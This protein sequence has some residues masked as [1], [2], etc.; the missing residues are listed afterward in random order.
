MPLKRKTPLKSS[1]FKKK[2]KTLLKIVKGYDPAIIDKLKEKGLV[3]SASSLSS[4]RKPS[5]QRGLFERIWNERPHLCEVCGK[6]IAEATASNFSHILPKGMY[7]E[8][9]LDPRNVELWC[10][11]CHAVWH[12]KPHIVNA[13]PIAWSPWI[14]VTQKRDEL[15]K[16]AHSFRV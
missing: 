14:R 15:R 5:G 7:P 10:E 8:Y 6:Q 12:E 4:K 3:R 2:P 13:A 11:K 9:K 16:E 1:G